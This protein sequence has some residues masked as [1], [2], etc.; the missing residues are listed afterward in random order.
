[1]DFA[2][3]NTLASFREALAQGAEG[4]ELDVHL[5]ACGQVVVIHDDTVDAT[6]DASGPVGLADLAGLKALDA[7]SW[8]DPRFKGERI[9]TLLEVFEA[10][11]AGITVDVEIKS[12]WSLDKAGRLALAG[13]AVDVV[14]SCRRQADVVFSSFDPRII[15]L[16]ARLAPEIPRGLLMEARRPGW[17]RLASAGLRMQALHP[18]HSAVDEA[19]MAAARTKGWKVHAW[20]VNDP[21]EA[22]RLAALGV[23]AIITNQPGE[24]RAALG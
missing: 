9:P 12:G 8:F 1:M 18:E 17:L 16:L 4:I 22:R 19:F 11:P 7:G 14:R 24:I 10:V 6:T 2:P 5:S 20:T 3:Q 13:L 23:N 15:R 21:A